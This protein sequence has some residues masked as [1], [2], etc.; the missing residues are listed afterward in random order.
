VSR[1]GSHRVTVS[2]ALIAFL[3]TTLAG[4]G[5]PY[6]IDKPTYAAASTGTPARVGAAL[7]RQ[8]LGL[9]A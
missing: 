1:A 2:R 6:P 8:S 5:Q 9:P 7:T 4:N 3:A